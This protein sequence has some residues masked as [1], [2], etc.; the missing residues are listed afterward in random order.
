MHALPLVSHPDDVHW[1][2]GHSP[3]QHQGGQKLREP[4]TTGRRDV[5]AA[6]MQEAEPDRVDRYVEICRPVIDTCSSLTRV[7]SSQDELIM[8]KRTPGLP[9]TCHLSA[10]D[11]TTAPAKDPLLL[12]ST[13]SRWS[14]PPG[15]PSCRHFVRKGADGTVARCLYCGPPFPIPRE[16]HRLIAISAK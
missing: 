1:K 8:T 11:E 2:T 13:E 16:F 5:H 10:I 15:T 7:V 14:F 3:Y 12:C 6:I 9:K 4:W